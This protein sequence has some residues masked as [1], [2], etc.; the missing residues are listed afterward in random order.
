MTIFLTLLGATTILWLI[1]IKVQDASIADLMWGMFFVIQGCM[2]YWETPN[3]RSLLLMILTGIWGLRL[4][5]YLGLRNHGQPED[6]RYR[7][8]RA[9][10]G[11][12]FWWRSYFTV[13]L[14]QMLI[15]WFVGMPQRLG[16]TD[17]ALSLLDGIGII[18]W[19]IGL[20]FE[21]IGDWQLSQFL[22]NGNQDGV[23]NTGLWRYTRHPNY[24]GDAFLWWGLGIIAVSG[25]GAFWILLSPLLMTGLLLKVSGVSL[26]EKDISDRRPAY[27]A[28]IHET[29]AFVPW[30]PKTI[31]KQ[32]P[33]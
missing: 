15:A 22:R 10:H 16:A 8:M 28:Y 7:A 13:F 30:F 24:F 21:I 2:A 14:F 9:N 17:V 12:N 6:R 11:K 27:Q 23:L 3:E 29:S 4:S 20:F 26:L 5:I 33:E 25:T 19:S 18:V 32:G 31:S 1:S